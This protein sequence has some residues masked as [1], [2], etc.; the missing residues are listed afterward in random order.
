MHDRSVLLL[1]LSADE[2][3][4]SLEKLTLLKWKDEQGTTQRLRLIREL[5]HEWETI[6]T[7]L[8]IGTPKL[9]NLSKKPEHNCREVFEEWITN[10]GCDQYP[11]SWD[12][13]SE[14]LY[15]VENEAAAKKLEEALKQ[16][17]ENI[18]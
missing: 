3:V 7:L 4:P 2:S 1:F 9:K 18:I 14:L 8:H 15:D 12:G 13:I 5:S 11:L 16:I 17:K 6:G 10:H